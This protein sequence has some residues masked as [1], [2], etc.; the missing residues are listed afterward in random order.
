METPQVN[1]IEQKEKSPKGSA[2]FEWYDSLVFALT[3]IVLIFV[4]LVRI[5]TVSGNS[6]NPTLNWGDRIAVQSM[7]YTP[8]RGDVVVV[9]SYSQYGD[10]LVK[11]VIAV[12]GDTLDIHFDTGDVILNG[13]VLDEPYI[14]APTTDAADVTF[15]LEVPEGCV[16]VMGDNRPGSLDSRSTD[17]G[18]IDARDILGKV[19][20]R[21]APFQNFGMIS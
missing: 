4:F 20:M 1:G 6:M 21:V 12:G 19:I 11:R 8:K 15:P 5:I 3:V 10:P 16:F 18:F 14:L 17:I 7:L 13:E 2:L 9:D